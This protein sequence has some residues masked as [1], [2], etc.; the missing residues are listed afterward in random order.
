MVAGINFEFILVLTRFLEVVLQVSA[1]MQLYD[2]TL[3]LLR[4]I[5]P[6]IDRLRSNDFRDQ[7]MFH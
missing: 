1:P 5:N 7:L 2:E 3:F 6:D 4:W